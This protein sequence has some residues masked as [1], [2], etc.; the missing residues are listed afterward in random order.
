MQMY[1]HGFE[2]IYI[3]TYIDIGW[4]IDF[5]NE[6]D[7]VGPCARGADTSSKL[8]GQKFHYPLI[9][10]TSKVYM[11]LPTASSSLTFRK[12]S[13]GAET[14]SHSLT[15]GP[16][17][18]RSPTTTIRAQSGPRVWNSLWISL[19][20]RSLLLYT[21]PTLLPLFLSSSSST[22]QRDHF[23]THVNIFRGRCWAFP[24]FFRRVAHAF[25]ISRLA[26]SQRE[27]KEKNIKK[28]NKNEKK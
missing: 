4:C 14:V 28:K 8:P 1:T 20:F 23:S 15:T 19:S 25:G 17:V 21:F 26:S 5:D 16:E 3:Y 10:F 22:F 13:Q 6:K 9:A 11:S 12:T 27:A 24:Q 18:C 2:Y 7:G